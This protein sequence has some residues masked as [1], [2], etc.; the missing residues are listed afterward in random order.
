M[1]SMISCYFCYYP[2]FADDNIHVLP[3][4]HPNYL[5]ARNS[6]MMTFCQLKVCVGN[7]IVVWYFSGTNKIQYMG[8]RT[9][10]QYGMSLELVG[11]KQSFLLSI[12][13]WLVCSQS[14][15]QG[16]RF[17]SFQLPVANPPTN[18]YYE[19]HLP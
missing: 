6:F 12:F 11:I 7:V 8:C 13:T 3:H 9:P 5:W 14:I 1:M 15:Y 10:I 19:A 17:F 2:L 16:M 4:L 18:M